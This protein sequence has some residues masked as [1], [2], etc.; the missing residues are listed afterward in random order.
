MANQTG[1]DPANVGLTSRCV[2]LFTTGPYS[3]GTVVLFSFNWKSKPI[4][5]AAALLETTFLALYAVQFL[6]LGAP[7]KIRIL[8]C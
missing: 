6:E 3:T 7:Y 2:F 8:H 4:L 1:N 5:V